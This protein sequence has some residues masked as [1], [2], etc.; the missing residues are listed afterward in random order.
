MFVCTVLLGSTLLNGCTLVGM[1]LALFTPASGTV[2]NPSLI[3]NAAEYDAEVIRSIMGV[4]STD[5]CKDLYGEA[6]ALCKRRAD[7]ICRSI[8][9]HQSKN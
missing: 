5:R 2:R 6:Q 3:A 9:K 7:A 4:Q 8:E 1:S